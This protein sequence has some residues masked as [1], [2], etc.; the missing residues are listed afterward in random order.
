M[1]LWQVS[2]AKGNCRQAG[3]QVTLD[4]LASDSVSNEDGCVFKHR[5]ARKRVEAALKVGDLTTV[6]VL[7]LNGTEEERFEAANQLF[8]LVGKRVDP[9]SQSLGADLLSV[10]QK[11]PSVDVRSQALGGLD[12]VGTEEARQVLLAALDEPDLMWFAAA[13]LGRLKEVRA[14]PQLIAHLSS[15]DPITVQMAGQALLD[16]DTPEARLALKQNRKRLPGFLR[17]EIPE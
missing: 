6:R 5:K 11:D 12:G 3:E 16:I 7:L 13:P 17:E 15:E 1:P 4:L 2:S 10:A 14:V 9:E 8:P